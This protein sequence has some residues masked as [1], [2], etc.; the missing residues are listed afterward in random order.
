VSTFGRLEF[1]IDKG[2]FAS[3]SFSLQNTAQRNSADKKQDEY[4]SYLTKEFH[5]MKMS[6]LLAL[7]FALLMSV[8]ALAQ[9]KDTTTDESVKLWSKSLYDTSG[10]KNG[11]QEWVASTRDE[12]ICVYF[13]V[14]DATNV[15]G[16]M[17]HHMELAAN[18][19]NV[20]VAE[21]NVVNMSLTWH[22][23]FLFLWYHGVCR[24]YSSYPPGY[25]W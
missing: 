8:T 4:T 23:N 6:R 21:Y 1:R 7:S 12:T 13:N 18:S 19:G 20:F 25:Q 2:I 10:R 11:T 3:K 16:N 17:P 5:P 24:Q 22:T 14:D 15:S 9:Y